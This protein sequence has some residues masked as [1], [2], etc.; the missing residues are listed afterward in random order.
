MNKSHWLAIAIILAAILAAFWF[1]VEKPE[2]SA[3]NILQMGSY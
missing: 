1:L 3:V 2:V